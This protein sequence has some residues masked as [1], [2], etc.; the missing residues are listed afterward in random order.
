MYMC[1]YCGED[2]PIDSG[3]CWKCGSDLSG[4]GLHDDGDH[5][6]ECPACSAQIPPNAPPND[7]QK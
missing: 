6:T 3:Q 1:P 2:A 4:D 7:I 5:I